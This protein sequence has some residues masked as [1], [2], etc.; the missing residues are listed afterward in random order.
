MVHTTGYGGVVESTAC[1]YIHGIETCNTSYQLHGIPVTCYS[2]SKWSAMGEG[3]HCYCIAQ[4]SSTGGLL[5]VTQQRVSTTALLYW[6]SLSRSK[7]N[8][9]PHPVIHLFPEVDHSN[10]LCENNSPHLD[11]ESVQAAWVSQTVSYPPPPPPA[12]ALCLHQEAACCQ[13]RAGLWK[14]LVKGGGR[15]T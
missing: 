6:G 15:G 10:F 3:Y 9:S 14:H 11:H 12:I 13:R 4:A 7:V 2:Q 8:G 5:P 1:V